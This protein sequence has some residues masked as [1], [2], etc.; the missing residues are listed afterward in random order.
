MESFRLAT[1]LNMLNIP[2]NGNAP[3]MNALL[4]NQVDAGFL[5]MGGSTLQHIQAGTLVPIAT[6]GKRD[7]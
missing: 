6:S 1:N 4:G 5:V 2:F 3:A 7:H